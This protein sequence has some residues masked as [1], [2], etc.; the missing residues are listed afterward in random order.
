M[1]ILVVSQNF[2]PEQFRINDICVELVNRGHEVTVLTG[3]PNYPQG[4]IYAGYEKNRIATRFIM[5]LK[6]YVCMNA[7]ASRAER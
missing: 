3:L 5:A 2:Y 7:N 6:L 1:K 4:K